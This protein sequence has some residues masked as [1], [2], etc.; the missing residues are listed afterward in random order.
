[1]VFSK[2]MVYVAVSGIEITGMHLQGALVIL[3]LWCVFA[4][5]KFFIEKYNQS[6]T[7]ELSSAHSFSSN[8]W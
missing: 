8:F 7:L 3:A 1:M 6:G 5:V 4:V 2:E